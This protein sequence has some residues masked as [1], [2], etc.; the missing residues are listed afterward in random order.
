MFYTVVRTVQM[1]EQDTDGAESMKYRPNSTIKPSVSVSTP[2]TTV[3]IPITSIKW[4]AKPVDHIGNNW[5]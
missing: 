2:A 5:P 1:Q 3:K 4:T